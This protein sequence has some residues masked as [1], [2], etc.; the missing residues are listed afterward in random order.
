MS[1]TLGVS[2]P[3]RSYVQRF[4]AREHPVMR[5]CREETAAL[6]QARMQVSCEQGA[7]MQVLAKAI[8]ARRAIEVGVFTGYSSL[9][10]ALAMQEIHGSDACLVACD[11]SEDY[12]ARARRYWAQAGVDH[13]IQLRLGPAADTLRHLLAEGQADSFDLAFIHADKTG[14]DAYY[15]L[16]LQLLRPGGMMLIDNMLWGGS[17]AEPLNTEADTAA[18]RALAAKIHD[19]KRVDMALATIGDGLSMV[20][21]R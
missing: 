8:H 14:Y 4:G 16:C 1:T 2:E 10:V 15:E 13:T 7:V 5:R 20:V 6:E 3:V 21:K 17:V 11:I 9:A 18:L 12:V 19:D